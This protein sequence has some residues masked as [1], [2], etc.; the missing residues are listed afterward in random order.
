MLIIIIDTKKVSSSSMFKLHR[1]W[2]QTTCRRIAVFNTCA[3]YDRL[4]DISAYVSWSNNHNNFIIIAEMQCW[5]FILSDRLFSWTWRTFS[6]CPI[7][8]FPD[9]FLPNQTF[10]IKYFIPNGGV[11]LCRLEEVAV[12]KDSQCNCNGKPF[13]GD[14]LLLWNIIGIIYKVVSLI[15]R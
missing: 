11:N 12:S 10:C 15:E 6:L 14:I 3:G 4:F 13:M 9:R 2:K 1:L 7:E 8:D 5:F